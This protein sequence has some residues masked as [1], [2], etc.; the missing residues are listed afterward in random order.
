VY[1]HSIVKRVFP[2]E[3]YGW[4]HGRTTAT[5][6][7]LAERDAWEEHAVPPVCL[8]HSE[9]GVATE[10]R[11]L[12]YAIVDGHHRLN[13]ARTECRQNSIDRPGPGWHPGHGH[14]PLD[15]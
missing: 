6:V 12:H 7:D 4:E 14:S 5:L 1:D 2:S 10:G 15:A 9:E 3:V 13:A 8:A 11:I